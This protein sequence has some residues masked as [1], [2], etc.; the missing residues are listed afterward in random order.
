VDTDIVR[1]ALINIL[2]NAVEAC[3]EDE[4]GKSHRIAFGVRQENDDIVFYISDNGSGMDK[5][6]KENMFNLFFSSK[7][8]SGTGL[9]LFIANQMV[10]Q[11]GGSIRVES[12]PGKGSVFTLRLP[13]VPP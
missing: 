9:G 5:E 3:I 12:Q 6:T 8:H 7:G 11:H 2:E 1:S 4:S 10:E 13:T